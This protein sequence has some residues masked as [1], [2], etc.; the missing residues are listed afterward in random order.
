MLPAGA[1][2]LVLIVS[3]VSS[4]DATLARAWAYGPA[5]WIGR[6]T[7]WAEDLLHD[8]GRSVVRAIAALCG[9]LA[10]AGVGR[11]W[12]RT[13]AY[14]FAAIAVSALVAGALKHVT[15]IDCPWDVRGF[16]GTRPYVHVLGDRPD[17][18]PHAAC[19]PGAHA[20]S[21]FALM[22]FYF[23]FRDRSK[24]LARLGLAT[25]VVTGIA[26]SVAQEA[27]GAHFLSHDVTS[28]FLSWF[29]CLAL[30]R[31]ML[32]PAPASQPLL[33]VPYERSRT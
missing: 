27:R 20:A 22:A 16:G 8:G 2:V 10:V 33:E 6:G 28:A 1:C 32:Q 9:I 14:L 23:A 11:S 3:N 30:Y 18:L 12:R 13:A 25:A 5:G 7:W 31:A 17:A 24:R 15:N 4:L 26:F 29:T 19:F 21:G